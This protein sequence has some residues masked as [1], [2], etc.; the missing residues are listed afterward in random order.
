MTFEE[1]KEEIQKHPDAE[2]CPVARTLELV[3]GK[4]TARVIFQLEKSQA[5]R[6]GDL[7]RNIRGITNTMLSSTLKDLEEKGLVI[8]K[9]YEEMP[10]RVEYSLTEKVGTL[11]LFSMRLQYG[12]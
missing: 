10:V 2:N 7:R 8:R 9:Q 5:S 4:W 1:F 6:F 3:S 11:C 12:A